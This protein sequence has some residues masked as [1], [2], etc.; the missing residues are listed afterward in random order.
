M[1]FDHVHDPKVGISFVIHFLLI[2][3]LF[4]WDHAIDMQCF[5][6]LGHFVYESL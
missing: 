4:V 3:C 1:E 6:A 5:V 2:A